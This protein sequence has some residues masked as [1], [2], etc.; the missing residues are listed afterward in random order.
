MADLTRA[1]A[2]RR[3]E[4]IAAEQADGHVVEEHGPEREGGSVLPARVCGD[5]RTDFAH[6][7]VEIDVVGEGDLDDPVDAVGRDGP[8]VGSG[9]GPVE[10]D[11]VIDRRRIHLNQVVAAPDRANDGGRAPASKLRGQ[12]SDASQHAVHQHRRTGDRP[13]TKHC[14]MSSDA[15]NAKARGDVIGHVIG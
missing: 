12:A 9:I 6:G 13:V 1:E 8:D 2:S 14:P 5:D 11:D 7:G 15:R 4:V 10:R 3:G